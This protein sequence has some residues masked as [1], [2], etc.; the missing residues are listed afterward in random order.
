[1]TPDTAEPQL[2]W[3][4]LVRA[5]GQPFVITPI[6]QM[7]TAGIEPENQ[8]AASSLFNIMRNLGGSIGIA[9]LQTL[10]TRREHFHFDVI[11]QQVTQNSLLLQERLDGMARLFLERV[12]DFAEARMMALAQLQAMVRRNAY[13]MAY[14]DCFWIMGVVLLVSVLAIFFMPKASPGAAPA[15]R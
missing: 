8:A 9:L 12:G 1:M 11:S 13:V 4:L 2:R 6:S 10:T 3:A 14:A 5:L 7:A 15:G